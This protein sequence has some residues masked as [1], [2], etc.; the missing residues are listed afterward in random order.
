MKDE[1]NSKYKIFETALRL[2]SEKGYEAVGV[3]QLCEET[4]ITKPTL[5]YFFGSKINLL[6]EIFKCN[7]GRF[8]QTLEKVSVYSPHLSD[9]EKDVYPLLVNVAKT[10]FNF[11]TDNKIFYSLML[12]ALT[13][14][15][16]SD[17]R[18]V[19][20]DFIARQNGI[21]EQMFKDISAFHGNVQGREK[22]LA[23]T[24]RG[25]INTYIMLGE[26]KEQNAEQLVHDFMHGIFS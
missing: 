12:N 23:L 6:R 4:G 24:F 22:R 5:Y 3:Q 19:A 16:A 18:V 26:T 17:I 21:I 25:I 20:T 13:A 7:Y 2:F 9:Y 14:P 8:N 11:A 1:T 10:F 15:G